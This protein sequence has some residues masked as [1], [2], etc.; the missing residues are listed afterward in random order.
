MGSC[1]Y[2]VKN[3]RD[4]TTAEACACLQG[5]VFAEEMGFDELIV[6]GDSMIVIKKLQ[7]PENDRS[8]IGVIINEIKGKN[9]KT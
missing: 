9:Q 3:V 8:L 7:S 5:V 2:S 6:E 1:V 4:P